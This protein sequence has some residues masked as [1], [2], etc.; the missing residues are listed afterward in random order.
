MRAVADFAGVV[1]GR[2]ETLVDPDEN[3]YGLEETT[4]VTAAR[5]V[6]V[7]SETR[8]ALSGEAVEA[9][10]ESGGALR[11][12]TAS[13]IASQ[14]W[15]H[16]GPEMKAR[17]WVTTDGREGELTNLRHC[18]TI[19]LSPGCRVCLGGRME[20]YEGEQSG[21]MEEARLALAYNKPLYLMGGFGGA[22]R[23]FGESDGEPYWDAENGLNV[24][25]KR[26]LFK[27]TDVEWAL[28]LISRG[29][30]AQGQRRRSFS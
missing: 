14:F 29:V 12:I 22:A 7:V 19:M 13:D 25:E 28:G 10:R 9:E 6:N 30:D 8:D 16:W 26:K 27:T 24:E 4:D 1:A 11:V 17:G 5:M 15:G 20:G 2:R 3:S 23:R 21:V 18:L